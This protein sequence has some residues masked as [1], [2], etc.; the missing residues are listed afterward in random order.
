VTEAPV[1]DRR[2]AQAKEVVARCGLVPPIALVSDSPDLTGWTDRSSDRR[3]YAT[4]SSADHPAVLS[5][6]HAT[7]GIDVAVM[8]T[9]V[10]LTAASQ[11]Q[12]EVG[13]VECSP[14][15]HPRRDVADELPV[16]AAQIYCAVYST[17][18]ADSASSVFID[19]TGR[20]PYYQIHLAE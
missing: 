9:N 20:P 5:C 10:R 13:R 17:S 1:S 6:G 11:W 16:G 7:N 8:M 15:E 14:R 12:I 4:D 2:C 3:A 19:V 18:P